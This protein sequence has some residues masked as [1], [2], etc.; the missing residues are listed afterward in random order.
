MS[1]K[2]SSGTINPKTNKQK[3][4]FKED[5]MINLL[6]LQPPKAMTSEE[7]YTLTFIPLTLCAIIFVL[8][9]SQLAILFIW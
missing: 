3:K 2:F 7:G 5:L 6:N 1:E 4:T 8:G 9:R